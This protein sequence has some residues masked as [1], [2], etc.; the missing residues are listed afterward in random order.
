MDRLM[1][2]LLNFHQATTNIATSGQPDKAQLHH[3]AEEGY[4]AVVN[5]AMHDSDNALNDEGS[6]VASLGMSYFNIPVPFEEPTAKHLQDFIGLMEV[7]EGRKVWVH[8]AVNARVSAF[9]FQCLTQVK[10][11]ED[12]AATSPILVKWRNRM[13]DAWQT[14]MEIDLAKND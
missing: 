5:L 14:F 12:D 4:E 2:N 9:M 13:D 1:D 8:C 6:I 11:M 10:G 3:I 7:L